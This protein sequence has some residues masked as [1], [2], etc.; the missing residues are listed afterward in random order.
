MSNLRLADG[1]YNVNSLP[2]DR[3]LEQQ[4]RYCAKQHVLKDLDMRNLLKPDESTAV[5][6]KC[7]LG[8]RSLKT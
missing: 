1:P 5:T 8:T 4:T 3:Y 7:C 2:T 6:G